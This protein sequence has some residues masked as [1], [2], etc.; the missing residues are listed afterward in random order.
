MVVLGDRVIQLGIEASDKRPPLPV[1]QIWAR[2]VQGE[3]VASGAT[4]AAIDLK[5]GAETDISIVCTSADGKT[6]A[7][8]LAWSHTIF[9]IILAAFFLPIATPTSAFIKSLLPEEDV[10]APKKKAGNSPGRAKAE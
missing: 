7:T 10:T 8:V 3:A 4:S 5:A 1:R 2:H 9:N 6:T